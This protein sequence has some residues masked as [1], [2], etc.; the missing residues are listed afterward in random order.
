MHEGS[1][2]VQEDHAE[3]EDEAFG[4]ASG[5]EA[6]AL[7]STKSIHSGLRTFN[8][9]IVSNRGCNRGVFREGDGHTEPLQMPFADVRA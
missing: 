9:R 5:E 1:I 3:G 8:P 6:R 4:T 7:Y 2:A